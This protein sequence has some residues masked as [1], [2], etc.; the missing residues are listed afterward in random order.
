MLRWGAEQGLKRKG[1]GNDLDGGGANRVESQKDGRGAGG[2]SGYAVAEDE[3]PAGPSAQEQKELTSDA[4]PIFSV[5]PAL[6]GR[7]DAHLVP[8]FGHGAPGYLKSVLAQEFRQLLVAQGMV[9][10]FAGY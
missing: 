4:G 3:K 1:D 7:G 5:P 2:K 10:V 8:V 9:P 6:G